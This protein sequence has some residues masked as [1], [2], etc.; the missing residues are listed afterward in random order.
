MFVVCYY[1]FLSHYNHDASCIDHHD[2]RGDGRSVCP[3]LFDDLDDGRG[4][5]LLFINRTHM[6]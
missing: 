2:A 1:V 4:G 3:S 6:P 5:R